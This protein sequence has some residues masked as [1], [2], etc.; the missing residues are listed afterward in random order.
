MDYIL[1]LNLFLRK[2]GRDKEKMLLKL[3][4]LST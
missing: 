4:E 2:N 3:I 1:M